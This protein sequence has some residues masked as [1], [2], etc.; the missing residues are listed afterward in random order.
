MPPIRTR[1]EDGT[2]WRFRLSLLLRRNPVLVGF[3][4]SLALS[5]VA[6]G[7]VLDEQGKGRQR[8]RALASADQR[9]TST[10]TALQRSRVEAT[11]ITCRLNDDQNAVLLGL[12]EFSV[13]FGKEN[14]RPG[15]T[16]EQR[17]KAEEAFGKLLEP[18]RPA[19]TRAVCSALLDTIRGAHG[20]QDLRNPDRR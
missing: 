20:Q 5:A 14:P 10:L 16:A 13:R 11:R 9:I 15:I 7:L 19:Q 12:I 2:G 17:A 4:L 18:I 1:R 8:D 3:T 6:L